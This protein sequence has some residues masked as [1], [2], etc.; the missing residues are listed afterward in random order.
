MPMH[1]SA[2]NKDAEFQTYERKPTD[3]MT[4]STLEEVFKFIHKDVPISIEVKD[5]NSI[6]AA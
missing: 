2:L 4:F 6:E 5:K 1:F 3:Q